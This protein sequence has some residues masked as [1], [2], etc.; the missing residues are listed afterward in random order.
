MYVMTAK[1]SKTKLA[2]ALV[3]LIALAVLVVMLVGGAGG[4][5]SENAAPEGFAGDTNDAR[6]SFL[7]QYGWDVNAEP[8]K[9]QQVTIPALEEDNETFT[10]YNEL[11]K[12]QGFDLTKFAGKTATRYVYEILN[13]PNATE[14][15]HATLF[16][17]DGQI[18][19]GDVTDTSPGG[20]MHGFALPSAS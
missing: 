10:R 9:T 13:Y 3:L 8:I 17:A 11:Q 18:I 12:S 7:A 5:K 16:V 15:V 2:G 19:G 6:L 4:M 14:P 1:L 20:K